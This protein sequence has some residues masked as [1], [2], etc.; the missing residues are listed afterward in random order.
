MTGCTTA[1]AR[2]TFYYFGLAD[3]TVHRDRARTL[4]FARMYIGEDAE[5]QN[6]DAEQDDPLAHH[7]Q[8]WAA[9]RQ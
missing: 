3:P 7:R 9:V 1:K 4:R 5:A 2:S 6:W 8:P